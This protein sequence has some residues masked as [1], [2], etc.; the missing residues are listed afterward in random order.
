MCLGLWA[1]RCHPAGTWR[2]AVTE[3]QG[4]VSV[5]SV[6]Q[7]LDDPTF[8]ADVHPLRVGT[9]EGSSVDPG[10]PRPPRSP[11][12]LRSQHRH[13]PPPRAHC[14]CHREDGRFGSRPIPSTHAEAHAPQTLPG[15]NQDLTDRC[16]PGVRTGGV[17]TPARREE[18]LVV[19]RGDGRS[20]GRAPSST[21]LA[22]QASPPGDASRGLATESA[23]PES[24]RTRTV[25]RDPVRRPARREHGCGSTNGGCYGRDRRR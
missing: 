4:L 5:S 18:G 2:L 3:R 25:P 15:R 19:T 24:A 9:R 14:A 20:Q 22:Q 23:G 21:G 6:W 16:F 1:T 11:V 8:G 7:S 17:Y 13:V 12:H 10:R